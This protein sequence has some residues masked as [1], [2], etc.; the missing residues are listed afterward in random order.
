M[1]RYLPFL[2]LVFGKNDI[3]FSISDA[4]NDNLFG[5]LSSD[6]SEISRKIH[7]F[8]SVPNLYVLFES[9]SLF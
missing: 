9:D 5:C 7:Y 6:T 1:R 8:D 3:A 2:V 4:L